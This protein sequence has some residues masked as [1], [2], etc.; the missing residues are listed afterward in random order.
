MFNK[1]TE[2]V[3]NSKKIGRF[4]FITEYLENKDRS[5]TSVS[6][7]VLSEILTAPLLK[8]CLILFIKD[9][10]RRY[11]VSLLSSKKSKDAVVAD[12]NERNGKRKKIS[13]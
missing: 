3:K 13:Y 1:R 11:M 10:A 5:R 7:E 12:I 9:D 4:C 8:Q 6:T 2:K